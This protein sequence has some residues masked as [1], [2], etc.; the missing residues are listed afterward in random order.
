MYFF[1][2]FMSLAVDVMF[3]EYISDLYTVQRAVQYSSVNCV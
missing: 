3:T 2:T 1:F